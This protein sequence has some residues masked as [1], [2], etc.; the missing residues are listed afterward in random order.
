MKTE[1]NEHG[2]LV[3]RA[4]NYTE[5]YALRALGDDLLN[6]NVNTGWVI[7]DLEVPEK[8]EEVEL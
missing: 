4:E 8:K 7:L 3:V 1:F 5:A 6:R 2:Q